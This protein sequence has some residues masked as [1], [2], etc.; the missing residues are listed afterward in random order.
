MQEFHILQTRAVALEADNIDTDQIMPKQF[1]RGIDKSGLDKGLFYN[2]KHNADGSLNPACVLNSDAARAAALLLAGP[3]FGCGSSREHA[4]WG[5]MQGG[6]KVVAA[7]NFGEIFYSN[8]FNNGLLACRVTPED[9]EKLFAVVRRSP[10]AV[11][12]VNLTEGTIA[13]EDVV[14]SF[15]VSDRHRTMLGKGLDM[16][17]ATL[18]EFDEI[19]AFKEKHEA[20]FPW[21]A[22]LPAQAKRALARKGETLAPDV[23]G[24]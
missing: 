9:I 20:A 21:M 3:N 2:L 5:L 6:F 8:C 18:V 24:R 17:D 10:E 11:F 12:T 23:A 15:A 1:L 7:P 4:V 22:G 16:V 13:A 14:V 19:K